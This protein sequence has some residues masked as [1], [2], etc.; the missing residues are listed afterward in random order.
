MNQQGITSKSN[1]TSDIPRFDSELIYQ[2]TPAE[3]I[4]LVLAC[5]PLLVCVFAVAPLVTRMATDSSVPVSGRTLLGALWIFG[6]AFSIR[7]TLSVRNRFVVGCDRIY[8]TNWRGTRTLLFE[9]LA[10]CTV[11]PESHTYQ[12][13]P[14]YWGTRLTFLSKRIGVAP[15]SLFIEERAPID[16]EIVQRLKLLPMLT[17]RSLKALEMA[18]TA[19]GPRK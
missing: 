11:T 10:S 17:P 4:Y 8:L 16:A 5:I 15:L 3:R 9:E 12:R 6:V 13:L 1:E 7:A 19:R 14:T 18:S 2:P